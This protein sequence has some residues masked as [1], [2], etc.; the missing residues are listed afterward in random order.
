MSY[1]G[2]GHSSYR[3]KEDEEAPTPAFGVEKKGRRISADFQ[4]S[5]SL[6]DMDILKK[7][8]DDEEATEAAG[9]AVAAGGG[10]GG[11]VQVL[12]AFDQ[13]NSSRTVVTTPSPKTYFGNRMSRESIYSANYA[14]D[15]LTVLDA[16]SN[17]EFEPKFRLKARTKRS[18]RVLMVDREV[19]SRK[20]ACRLLRDCADVIGEAEDMLDAFHKVKENVPL[21][22]V[23]LVDLFN[24]NS[25]DL[26]IVS[27]IR[28][29][30]FAGKVIGLQSQSSTGDI[31]ALDD[32]EVLQGAAIYMDGLICKPLNPSD[33]TKVVLDLATESSP[34]RGGSLSTSVSSSGLANR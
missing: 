8:A 21:Y 23:V 34:A 6:Q 4:K 26:E 20:M 30:G 24:V 7:S 25:D 12:L 32:S 28:R 17:Q 5:I 14:D 2:H 1:H 29:T 15:H 33:L 13:E 19:L 10:G 22:G 3:L 9:R 16:R 27:K 18:M 31:T 11:G